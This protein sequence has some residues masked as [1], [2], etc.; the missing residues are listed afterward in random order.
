MACETFG[1]LEPRIVWF[2]DSQEV[3]KTANL[4]T[5]E[6]SFWRVVSGGGIVLGT[7]SSASA[8]KLRF[9]ESLAVSVNISVQCAHRISSQRLI[10]SDAIQGKHLV[11]C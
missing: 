1:I 3:N 6:W 9:N 10:F 2:I 11:L 8:A 4:T 7:W 5:D